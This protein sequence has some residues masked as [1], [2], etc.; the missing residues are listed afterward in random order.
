M[1]ATM[2]NIMIWIVIVL[3]LLVGFTILQP[4][5]G[6]LFANGVPISPVHLAQL[7]AGSAGIFWG[8]AAYEGRTRN[9]ARIGVALAL[10]CLTT[11]IAYH[12][13]ANL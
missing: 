7:D 12:S 1:N 11:A 3:G 5:G 4:M 6:R 13:G 9:W 10:A 8:A 2:R